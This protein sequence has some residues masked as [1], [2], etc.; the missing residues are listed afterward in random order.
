M[1][2]IITA[3]AFADVFEETRDNSRMQGLVTAI[4]EIGEYRGAPGT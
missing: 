3:P 4:F 2:G 1:S